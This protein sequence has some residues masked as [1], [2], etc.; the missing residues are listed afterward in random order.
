MPDTTDIALQTLARLCAIPAVSYHERPVAD[1]IRGELEEA[2]LDVQAD[3]FGNLVATLGGDASKPGIGGPG[4]AFVAHMD[5]PGFEVF[6]GSK[7]DGANYVRALGGVPVA[8]L[9]RETPVLVVS[10]DGERT[11]ATLHPVSDEEAQA[12][13]AGKDRLARLEA[14]HSLSPGSFVVFDLPDFE[15]DG[16]V[17]RAR[18]LDDLA[19]CAAIVSALKRL[20]LRVPERP[21]YGVFT[22]AEE[23]GLIGARAMA[24]AGTLPPET[25]VVSVEA[26]SVIPGVA[27][28]DGPVVR[29]GDRTYSFDA[30]AEQVLVS[31]AKELGE[32]HE[33]FKW[34][35]ALMS[36]G[37]CEATAFAVHGYA[38]TG[39]AFPLGNYHNATTSIPDPQG[40][41]GAEYIAVADYLAG[42]DLIERSARAT[43]NSESPLAERLRT[44]PPG[45]EE[46]LRLCASD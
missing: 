22:R 18:A 30:G 39:I 35:R 44:V 19:G 4:I 3:G 38:T 45:Q 46:R 28:R 29:T 5:H 31:A 24:G 10:P 17:I 37:T 34:Q 27:Q 20:A 23:D 21:V 8:A 32:Q 6:P 1:A 9:R 7:A 16:A 36:G 14:S 13:G 33:R 43:N 12:V 42:V 2:R 26:S 41:I 15:L 40:G 11:A 25:I